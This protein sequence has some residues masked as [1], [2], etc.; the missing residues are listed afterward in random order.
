[1]K[2]LTEAL[3]T[4]WLSSHSSNGKRFERPHHRT[5]HFK[6]TAIE[7]ENLQPHRINLLP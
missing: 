1:M 2:G 5:I 3:D 7:I 6:V 4:P